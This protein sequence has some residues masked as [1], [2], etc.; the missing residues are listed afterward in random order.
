MKK[1]IAAISMC[2][3]DLFFSERWISYYGKRLGFK[4]LYLF[5]DGIDQ[6]LPLRAEKINCFQ[7]SH[8]KLNRLKAD[9]FRAKRISEFAKELHKKYDVV[10]ATDIDEFLVLDP[11]TGIELK[12]YLNKSFVSSSLS[13]LGIDVAQHPT[14]EKSIDKNKPFLSQRKYAVV[15]DRYTKPIISLEPLNWGSGFH[16]VKGKDFTID[17]NLFLFHFGLVDIKILENKYKDNELISLRWHNHLKRRHKLYKKINN[18]IPV[19]ADQLFEKA[20]E[21]FK[22]NRRFIGWNKPSSLKI[23]NLIKIPERFKD[24]V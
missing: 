2:R 4:N 10:L 15:S 19:E 1:R 14:F 24:L 22:K 13:A 23:Q 6:K 17:P 7:I 8:I 16:R 3:N 21:Y 9:R 20:R 11:N 12:E 18:Q 5:I